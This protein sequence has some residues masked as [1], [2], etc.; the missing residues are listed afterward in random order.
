[1]VIV[2]GIDS[3]HFFRQRAFGAMSASRESTSFSRGSSGPLIQEENKSI[4]RLRFNLIGDLVV[5]AI[6]VRIMSNFSGF[7]QAVMGSLVAA[8]D[9]APRQ[10]PVTILR[11]RHNFGGVALDIGNGCASDWHVRGTGIGSLR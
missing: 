5:D 4:R 6:E 3:T 2:H 11:E 8:S 1:L 7:L 10:H 9:L